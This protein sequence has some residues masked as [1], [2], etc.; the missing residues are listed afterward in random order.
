VVHT[1]PARK[2]AQVLRDK[3][4]TLSREALML[5]GI[6]GAEDLSERKA[7]EAKELR[8][9]ARELDDVARLE[10]ITVRQ[11]PLTKRNKKGEEKTYCR[12]VCSWQE[13]SK[14]VTKY[15]GSC[16]KMSQADALEKARRLKAEALK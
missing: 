15:L 5:V 6:E 4:S 16:Q 7:A 1:T 10:D 11:N 3:A 13:G 12:W 14:T 9:K 8:D 2:E